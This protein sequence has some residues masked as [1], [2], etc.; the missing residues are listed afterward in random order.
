MVRPGY[1]GGKLGLIG[2]PPLASI[3][4]PVTQAESSEEKNNMTLA[5]SSGVAT[6]CMGILFAIPSSICGVGGLVQK[7]VGTGPGKTVFTVILNGASSK[8]RSRVS[9]IT[10]IFAEA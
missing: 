3:C 7:S 8:A 9:P 2:I 10:P 1:A 4:S 5:I 6:L